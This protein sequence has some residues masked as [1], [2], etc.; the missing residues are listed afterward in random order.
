MSLRRRAK[1]GKSVLKYNRLLETVTVSQ[2]RVTP[3]PLQCTDNH[4]A[5]NVLQRPINF[6][7]IMFFCNLITE[8]RITGVES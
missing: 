7:S 3:M 6:S 1:T 2:F 5:F 4:L 8:R